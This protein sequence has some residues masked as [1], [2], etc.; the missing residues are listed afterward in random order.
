APRQNPV[1]F[2]DVRQGVHHAL[3]FNP[4][5]KLLD[6]LERAPVEV[7]ASQVGFPS[8]ADEVL[9]VHHPAGQSCS[10]VATNLDAAESGKSV[11]RFRIGRVEILLGEKPDTDSSRRSA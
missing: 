5:S 3:N 1:G 4:C 9:R 7:L 10:G 8:I 2:K 6:M 11:Q